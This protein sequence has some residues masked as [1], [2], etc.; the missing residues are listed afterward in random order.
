MKPVA[1]STLGAIAAGLL[2]SLLAP[3]HAVAAEGEITFCNEFP[4]LVYVAIAYE[5]TGATFMSRGWLSLDTG[6]CSVFDSAIRVKTFYYL[7]ESVPYRLGRRTVKTSWGHDKE[8]AIWER[9]NF[10]YY[11]AENR[12][13]KSTLVPFNKGP[14]TTGDALTV[15]VTFTEDGHVMTTI[16]GSANPAPAAG[17]EESGSEPASGETPAA[18]ERNN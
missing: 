10:Q 17:G 1:R 5:Q 3:P 14:E 16:P 15:T 8:F 12:V 11:G 18:R 2:A 4:H 6:D 13:L 9:D 7:G